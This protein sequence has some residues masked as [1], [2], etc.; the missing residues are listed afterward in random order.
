[1]TTITDIYSLDAAIHAD[2]VRL[3]AQD[4]QTPRD[5]ALYDGED[6]EL[7]VVVPASVLVEECAQLQLLP[8]GRITHQR[9]L[10]LKLAVGGQTPVPI[11]GWEHFR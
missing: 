9:G 7:I 6:F 5:H 10:W 11:R 8:L 4:R 1:M 2:A 3:A